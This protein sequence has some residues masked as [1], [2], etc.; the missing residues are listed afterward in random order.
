MIAKLES[1][2]LLN[3]KTKTKHRIPTNNGSNNKQWINNN[4]TTDQEGTAAQATRDPNAS[5]WHH[6]VALDYVIV[7]IL[8]EKRELGCFA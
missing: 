5:L 8:M 6:I 2:L 1:N 3:N 7:F 4:E